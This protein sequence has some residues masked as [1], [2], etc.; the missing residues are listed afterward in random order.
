MIA[1][2]EMSTLSIDFD[3]N[4]Y[5]TILKLAVPTVIAMLTQSIVNHIDVVFFSRLPSW[6]GS[7]AQAA[8]MPSLIIVWLFGGSLSA[9]S[10]GTQ[11]I[12]GRRFAEGDFRGAGAALTNAAF[13]CLVAGAVLSLVGYL[14]LPLILG[15]MITSPPFLKI[16]IC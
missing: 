7:N 3:A 14:S 4:R 11:A 13:F 6:E 12:T 10:V 1:S 8:L 5:R 16:A 9:I 2:A 15:A